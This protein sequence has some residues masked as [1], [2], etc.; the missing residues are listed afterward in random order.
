MKL[1]AIEAPRYGAIK[2]GISA[3]PK[4]RLAEMQ[5]GCPER[6]RL[7]GFID[8]G[9]QLE[10]E[11]HT[12]LGSSRIRGEWFNCSDDMVSLV[13]GLISDGIRS[14]VDEFILDHEPWLGKSPL[15]SRKSKKTNRKIALEEFLSAEL[16]ES[17][18]GNRPGRIG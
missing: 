1:Y 11:I 14:Q 17:L 15:R 13:A 12:I 9:L 7:L 18:I 3:N 2:F 4:D 6:L 8:G 5:V 16:N 10:R